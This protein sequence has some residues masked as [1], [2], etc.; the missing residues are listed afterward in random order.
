[1]RGMR[2]PD[3]R[4]P[5]GSVRAVIFDLDG[6]LVDSAGEIAAALNATLAELDRPPLALREVEALIGRGVR[7]LVER[8][9]RLARITSTPLDAAVGRFEAHYAANVGR[10]ATLFPGVREGLVRLA[11]AAI[12]MAVVTNKPRFFTE[13]LLG[14]LGI[15]RFFAALVAGD[16]G[17][18]RKP[19]GDMLLAA[20][21][22]MAV[23]IDSVVMLGDSENDVEAARN[24]GCLVWCV[25]YGYNEGRPAESLSGDRLVPSVQAAAE[26]LLRSL[27]VAGDRRPL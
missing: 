20:A 8:A 22:A 7:V 17:I 27:S 5:A 24:A 15:E 21:R 1:M 18:A 14:S 26:I 9:L 4:L 6:T 10:H 3:G 2:S 19:A 25:P 11:E 23:D 12:P 16:D 13:H